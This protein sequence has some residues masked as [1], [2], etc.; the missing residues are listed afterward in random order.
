MGVEAARAALADAPTGWQPDLLAFVTTT[1]PYADKTNATAMHAALALGDSVGAYDFAGAARSWSGAWRLAASSTMRTLLVA[2]DVRTGLPGGAD[3]SGGG[4]AAVAFAFAP[5]CADQPALVESLG[6]A[7]LTAEFLD[8]WRTPGEA[9][10]RTWEERFGETAYV[11]VALAALTDALKR[12]GITEEDVDHLIVTGLH[13]RA[14]R[15]VIAGSGVARA[16]VADD[17]MSTI[18][19]TGVTHPGLLLASVLD[20]ASQGAVIVLVHLADGADV[21]IMRV[22]KALEAYRARRATM[23][24]ADRAGQERKGLPYATFVTW[25]GMLERESPRRPDPDAPAGPPSRRMQAWKYSFTA[26]RCEECATRHLPP[27]RVCLSCHAADRM[28]PERLADV[29]GTI[30]TYTVDRLA[31][32]LSPPVVAAVIDFDGGGR[33]ICEMTDV[34]PGEVVIG[35]RVEMT[36]RRLHTASNGVHNYFWKAR[37][38]SQRPSDSQSE[39]KET[40]N[41]GG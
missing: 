40:A 41:E 13:G 16:A 32:S 23:S 38:A 4:D 6:E 9:A 8:R 21:M 31:Y 18:G 15:S 17:L 19:N 11:S 39:Q 37:P 35:D 25:R 24:I 2:S 10:S 3:E 20:R 34:D 22:T 26:S 33:Y 14:V 30:A 28:E 7:S 12:A 29:K 5:S 27:A 36:F 1:P